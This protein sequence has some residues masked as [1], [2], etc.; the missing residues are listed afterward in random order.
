VCEDVVWVFEGAI[1][2]TSVRLGWC[3]MRSDFLVHWTGKDIRGAENSGQL[4]NPKTIDANS[5][6]KYVT[7]LESILKNGL[8]MSRPQEKIIG[9]ERSAR[10]PITQIV[11]SPPI[12]CFTENRLSQTFQHSSRYGFLGLAV[13]RKFVLDRYGGPVQYLRNHT[14]E[15]LVAKLE[16]LAE[17]LI[18]GAQ[19]GKNEFVDAANAF[20]HAACFYKAMSSEEN[21]DSFDLLEE[22]EWRIVRTAHQ[23]QCG[24]IIEVTNDDFYLKLNPNDVKM[25]VSPNAEIRS[26]IASNMGITK[27]MRT[28]RPDFP[29][30]L[31]VEECAHF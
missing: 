2:L 9:G 31:T 18:S 20:S 10:I 27:W 3:Y 15:C 7:R 5:A 28:G 22:F 11:H 12:V 25:I 1:H 23:I 8:K 30:V 29:P 14:D 26:R 6:E 19:A 24:N 4:T 21:S 16:E 17:F 13:D